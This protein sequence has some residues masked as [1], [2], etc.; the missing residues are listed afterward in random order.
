MNGPDMTTH[1]GRPIETRG[2]DGARQGVALD[3]VRRR[4]ALQAQIKQADHQALAASCRMHLISHWVLN[5]TGDVALAGEIWHIERRVR[6]IVTRAR[7]RRV[8][9]DLGLALIDRGFIPGLIELRPALVEGTEQ[10]V[11]VR[12]LTLAGVGLLSVLIALGT[13]FGTSFNST[14][15]RASATLMRQRLEAQLL[16]SG[17]HNA[18][19]GNAAAARL[20]YLKVLKIDP[21]SKYGYYDLGVLYQQS[22]K[23]APAKAAYTDALLI[24][25]RFQP[26]LFNLAILDSTNE[27][28][29]ALE[30][31]HQLVK[32]SPKSPSAWFNMALLEA[33]MGSGAQAS[34]DLHRAIKL[35]PSL[36]ARVPPGDRA[37]LG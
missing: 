8:R 21:L 14:G 32:V 30:L 13:Y 31:Y 20:D 6:A 3:P 16:A 23:L 15:G 12:A 25:P 28:G 11:R 33:A 17:Q 18:A 9:G 36:S 5:T 1:R 22:A 4:V 19:I 10:Q 34:N 2:T 35:N 7:L 24:D 26:A 27:P 29:T 37:L